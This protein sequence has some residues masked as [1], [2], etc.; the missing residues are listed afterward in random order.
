MNPIIKID[1]FDLSKFSKIGA[2]N[3]IFGASNSGKT[4]LLQ[5]RIYPKIFKTYE[6]VFIITQITNNQG[7]ISMIPNNYFM[8]EVGSGITKKMPQVEI[9]NPL[10]VKEIEN[11]LQKI[12]KFQEANMIRDYKG[13]ILKDING[14]IIYKYNV[15]L[16]FDD[17]V[18]KKLKDSDLFSN[19]FTTYRHWKITLIFLI[20]SIYGFID[21]LMTSNTTYLTIYDLSGQ[22]TA[23][24]SRFIIPVVNKHYGRLKLQKKIDKYPSTMMIKEIANDIYNQYLLTPNSALI[25]D[26]ENVEIYKISALSSDEVNKLKKK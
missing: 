15:L 20:Q 5:K 24:I 12:K 3:I 23:I 16:I 6:Y 7:Y 10:N 18:S 9:C 8:K 4:F 25:F 26:M 14:D 11:E 1:E 21:S 2:R 22:R 19:I 13:N 17:I